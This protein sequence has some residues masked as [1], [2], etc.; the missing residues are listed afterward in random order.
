MKKVPKRNLKI[1]FFVI[2]NKYNLE[3]CELL[4]FYF[5][6]DEKKI[7]IKE[8]SEKND[9]LLDIKRKR[10]KIYSIAVRKNLK[11]GILFDCYKI[12]QHFGNV[13]FYEEKLFKTKEGSLVLELRFE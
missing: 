6:D 5:K 11:N 2:N 9:Y 8:H 4:D 3:N 1:N 7:H 10:S 13:E 12:W